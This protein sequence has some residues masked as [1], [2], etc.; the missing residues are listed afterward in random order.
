MI[1]VIIPALNESRYINTVIKHLTE[2]PCENGHEIIVVDGYSTGSSINEIHNPDV[3]RLK[4]EKGRAFQMNAGAERARGKI[5]LFL[6]ADTRL[7][8]DALNKIEQVLYDDSYVTGAFDLG[9]DSDKFM[10]KYASERASKRSRMNRIPYGDQAQS[11]LS[12]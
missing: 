7:P 10:L 4:S 11:G 2:Q 5:L 12:V 1:S 3:V 9:I 6:H 8:D